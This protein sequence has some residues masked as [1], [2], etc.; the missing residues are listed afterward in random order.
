MLGWPALWVGAG[1]SGAGLLLGWILAR[2]RLRIARWLLLL[3]GTGLVWALLDGWTAC[4][5][6]LSGSGLI[7]ALLGRTGL[8]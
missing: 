6:L 3:S 5:L 1:L 2:S 7:R 8:V 4:R